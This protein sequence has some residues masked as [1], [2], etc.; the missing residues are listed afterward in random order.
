MSAESVFED[1]NA[2]DRFVAVR[3][4]TGFQ[5]RHR[6]NPAG[7]WDARNHHWYILNPFASRIDHHREILSR[8]GFE[9]QD[10]HGWWRLRG[11]ANAGAF[12]I[13]VEELTGVAFGTTGDT[14]DGPDT[15]SVGVGTTQWL[16]GFLKRRRLEGPDGRPLYAY[17]CMQSEFTEVVER[18]RAR[19]NEGRLTDWDLRAFVL[20][21]AEWWQRHYDGG[22]WSWEPLLGYVRWQHVHFPDLYEPVRRALG[23]WRVELVRLGITNRYLGTFACQGG[24][25]LALVGETSRI[26]SYLRAVLKHVARYRQFVDDSIELAR[27]QEH[28]LC[29]PTL[30]RDYVFRLAADLVDAVLHLREHVGEGDVLEVLDRERMGWRE[31]MPLDLDSERARELLI[32]LLRDAKAGTSTG[33]TYGVERFLLSTGI[34]WR[35]GARVELPRSLARDVLALQLGKRETSLPLRMHV[36]V[37]GQ[38][39]RVIG[40]YAAGSDQFQLVSEDR[41]RAA[42]FWDEDAVGEFRLEFFAR[43]VI[44]EVIVRRGASLG[45]LPWVFR[46]EDTD[47]PFI[48]EGSVSDR[49]P[50]L[51]VLL[52]DGC[53]MDHG[54]ALDP[55]VVGRALWRVTDPTVIETA[56][57]PCSVKPSSSQM[58]DEDYRLSGERFLGLVSTYPLFR[59]D[60]RLRVARGADDGHRAVP[61]HEVSWRGRGGN[62]QERPDGFGLR[63]VRHV[64]QGALR[65]HDRVGL[66]PTS[67][68]LELRPGSDLS[69]GDLLLDQAGGVRVAEGG[70]E[71]QLSIDSRGDRVRVRVKAVEPSAPPAEVALRLQWAGARELRVCAPFPGEGARF[72]R[73][74]RPMGRTLAIDDVHG[75]RAT[76]LSTD[77]SQKFFVEGELR[78][79]DSVSLRTVTYFRQDLRRDGMRHELAL[80]ETGAMLR[81]LLGASRMPDARVV[82]RIL[83]RHEVE[84]ATADVR[85][86][87]GTLEHDPT[88]SSVLVEP[89][90][91]SADGTASFEALPLTRTDLEAE[92]LPTFGPADSP[93]GA[94][95][96]EALR[97]EEQPWLV[98]LRQ[99]AGVRVEPVL[100][101]GRRPNVVKERLTLREAL[102]LADASQRAERFE[103][104]LFESIDEQDESRSEENWS[105]LTEMMLCLEDLPPTAVD[106]LSLL[107]RCPTMLVRSLFQ[108]DTNLRQRLW[109]LDDELPFSWLL[110]P[111]RVWR[112]EALSA[113]EGLRDQLT[114]LVEEAEHLASQRVLSILDEGAKHLGALDTVATDVKV[115]LAGGSLSEGFQIAVCE[116]RDRRTQEHVNLLA[117]LDDWPPGDG[118]REWQVELAN[119][120]FLRQLKMWQFQELHRAR[121]PTFDTP[122]AAA[123]CCFFAK[124][125]PRTTFLVKRMRMHDPTWFDAAYRAAW[126]RLARVQDRIAS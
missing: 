49:S 5:L 87:A 7:G 41:I 104:T 31:S 46:G 34:G 119:G 110:M 80:V 36:R 20:Y 45:E 35:M 123:W 66:L 15:G 1:A 26:T 8:Y 96:P 74:G 3:Q 13:V 116:E 93:V 109:R 72:L 12:R 44:G 60:V 91:E 59:G 29:P 39:E 22:R 51:L 16:R 94:T 124:P 57:G 43:E 97:L 102:G 79:A 68:T 27:D 117:G 120:D 115:G 67:L 52:P 21:A 90:L 112:Q 92:T 85:R 56:G 113:Y 38:G 69:E 32:G 37:A 64:R 108:L 6:G 55:D 125:T 62:W 11:E 78:A 126:Y 25:P 95:L 18:L 82:L 70:S 83:D 99:D 75:V 9:Q 86:F 28:L 103:R 98:V 47:C 118:R 48:G 76:A 106:L 61:A 30:R 122:V 50:E 33:S 42:T 107:P 101:G 40:L 77:E 4:E 121:Q 105:F 19:G 54:E 14:K 73:D 10:G 71:S 24:L 89:A 88:M 84:H 63:E 2:S 58:V 23:W 17:R 65:H 81:L 100:V 53:R 114:D 111:R